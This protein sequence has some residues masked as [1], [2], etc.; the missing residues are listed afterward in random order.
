[1]LEV[2]LACEY[3]CD[4]VLVASVDGF[5]V[6]NASAGLD[7]SSNACLVSSLNTV[8]EGEECVTCH[9]AS[10]NLLAAVL[11]SKLEG[12][13]SVC[14]TGADTYRCAVFCKCNAVV[15]AAASLRD[16]KITKNIGSRCSKAIVL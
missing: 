4:A 14:L 8:S 2:S 15:A 7:Y 11:D 13:D 10:G 12:C 16:A 5:L 1:M 6:A 9:N 3:H